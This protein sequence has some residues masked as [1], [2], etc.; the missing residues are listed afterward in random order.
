MV[1]LS[2]DKAVLEEMIE[3]YKTLKHQAEEIAKQAKTYRDDIEGFMIDNGYEEIMVGAYKV[4]NKL[5]PVVT[6]DRKI[7]ERDY[8]DVYQRVAFV[9]NTTRLTIS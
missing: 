7:L 5:V 6:I 2:S 9:K 8:P 3:T 1:V 4:T